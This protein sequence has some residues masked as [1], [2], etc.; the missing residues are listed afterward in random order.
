MPFRLS[1]D[2]QATFRKF[3]LD[4]S[5]SSR[6]NL[7][8]SDT[9]LGQCP[10]LAPFSLSCHRDLLHGYAINLLPTHIPHLRDLVNFL[11]EGFLMRARCVWRSCGP[12]YAP[13]T[14]TS[15]LFREP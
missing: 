10:H 1:A 4:D 9:L 13:R 8:R 2:M 6:V 14:Y 7:V 11:L 5:S 15:Y 3:K 12:S